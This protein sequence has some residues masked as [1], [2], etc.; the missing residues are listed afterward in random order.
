[1]PD[2]QRVL[3]AKL[4]VWLDTLEAAERK[5]WPLAT[6][7][8]RGRLLQLLADNPSKVSTKYVLHNIGVKR[9]RR[10]MEF[11]SGRKSRT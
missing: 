3:V 7:T 1:M 6:T 2:P 9:R 8:A 11:L 4:K 5:G 10:L